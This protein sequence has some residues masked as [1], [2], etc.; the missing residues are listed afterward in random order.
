MKYMT[1]VHVRVRTRSCCSGSQWKD[2]TPI[3]T[4]QREAPARCT[5]REPKAAAVPE[6]GRD[7][8]DTANRY[9]RTKVDFGSSARSCAK[10]KGW[11]HA[12]AA[13]VHAQRSRHDCLAMTH[14]RPERIGCERAVERRAAETAS[15]HVQSSQFPRLVPRALRGDRQSQELCQCADAELAHQARSPSVR[16]RGA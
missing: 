13:E 10:P 3:V 16:R 5:E 2:A 15:D 6:P 7:A 4:D 12:G 8:P 14:D 11:R 9:G 1:P